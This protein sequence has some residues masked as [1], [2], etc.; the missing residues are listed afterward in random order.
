MS[1]VDLSTSH[2]KNP[3]WNTVEIPPDGDEDLPLFAWDL[4]EMARLERERLEMPERWH[5][6]YRLF[7]KVHRLKNQIRKSKN[8]IEVNLFFANIIRTVANITARNPVAEVVDLDGEVDDA[9]MVLT[10]QLKKWWKN[11]NQ[12]AKLNTT[13]LNM[14]I[15]GITIEKPWYDRPNK[16]PEIT[17]TDCFSFFPAPG[18]YEDLSTDLPYMAYAYPELVEVV[19]K[20]FGV[21]GVEPDE[22]YS[23]LGEEREE[24]RPIPSGTRT[25]TINASGNYTG[26]KHPAN[27]QVD[28]REQRALVVELWIR[29]Y[30]TKKT[31]VLSE[32]VE[33]TG[34]EIYNEV[35]ELIY[36]DG[37]RKITVTNQGRLLLDDSPN[38]NINWALPRELSSK[39][40]AWGRFPVYGANSYID[41]NSIWGFSAAEQIAD[42]NYKI[43]EI[44]S[45]MVNYIM[46]KMTPPF[47]VPQGYGITRNMINNNPGLVLMPT[48]PG[49]KSEAG[50]ID[51]PNLSADFFKVLD[52]LLSLFDR[53]YQIEDADRGEAPRGVI[54]HAAIVA[55]QERNAVLI[56]HKINSIDQIVENRGKWA[57]SFYQNFGTEAELVDV[58]GDTVEFI[59]VDLAGRS[60]NYVVESGS[61]MPRTSLQTEEQAKELYKSGVIDRQALLETINFP[62]WKEIIERIGEGQLDQALQI[63]VQAGLPEEAAAELKMVLMQ[64]QGGPGNRKQNP[65]VSGQG[66][67][68][69]QEARV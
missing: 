49:F 64:P 60:F 16:R 17:V 34:E 37:V 22:I 36:P 38:P 26:T 33:D 67:V 61:T 35:E 41:T 66:G 14:E 43:N 24:N 50:Y 52:K 25:G 27:K 68:R 45:R 28:S 54:A 13:A 42:L 40:H 63:L 51:V 11:T 3:K 19:E 56:Q 32:V 65:P 39:T 57:I 2:L 20:K 10:A 15:Y 31:K 9:D 12:R 4:F 5:E 23:V 29:D 48:K 21:E 8:F 53:I 6:N 62:K 69:T 59:G 47:V 1:N 30:S 7:R 44:I 58:Q 46:R 55:L 18:I